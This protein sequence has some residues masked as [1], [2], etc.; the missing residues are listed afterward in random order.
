[1]QLRLQIAQ[2]QETFLERQGQFT[3]DQQKDSIGNDAGELKYTREDA[4]V[5]R[6]LAAKGLVAG[7]NVEQQD[8]TVKSSEF[9]VAH[10]NTDWELK[11]KQ[12]EADAG[13]R[14]RAVLNT[15][16]DMT[17][18][19]SFTDR[20]VRLSGNTVDNVT[21]QRG[22]AQDDLAKTAIASPASGLIVLSQLGDFQG[23]THLPRQGDFISQGR[24]VGEIVSL[25]Q[26]EV[27]LEL[28]Q[29]QITGV[30]MGQP[31]EVVIE[32]LPGV[33]L[34]G[35]VSSIGQTARRPPIE[36]WQGVSSS[37]TFPVTIDLPPTGKIMLRPGMQAD[38]TLVSERLPNVIVVPTSCIF[39]HDRQSIVF[40]ARRPSL[41]SGARDR[42]R[43]QRRLHRD[44]LR[45]A[46]RRTPRPQ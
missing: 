11:S 42:G 16:R 15:T 12:A 14:H 27:K 34:K 3:L 20:S 4:E 25:E 46:G 7:T 29:K 36:G 40:A 30:R 39:H 31:A 44:H 24:E 9:S 17:W 41:P 10:E 32:A 21:L 13:T 28:D 37:A 33:V 5:T 38:V 35:K 8:A 26:M 18:T 2:D 6:R 19:R 43:Q 23:D 1:M 22:R 45:L